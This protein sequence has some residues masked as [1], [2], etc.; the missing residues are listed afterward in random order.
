M[1]SHGNSPTSSKSTFFSILPTS[2]A[3]QYLMV[4]MLLAVFFV[5]PLTLSGNGRSNALHSVP[6]S[7]G[8]VRT[9]NAYETDYDDVEIRRSSADVMVYVGVWVLR[10][11]VTVLCFGWMSLKAIPRIIANSQDSIQFWRSKKQAEED[12]EKVV[13]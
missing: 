8:S 3:T 1:I 12:I 10:V 7:A 9:I 13:K 6:H 4:V 5:N 2:G 11:V